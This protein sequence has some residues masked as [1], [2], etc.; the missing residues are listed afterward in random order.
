MYK[1]CS[2]EEVCACHYPHCMCNN[3]GGATSML[4]RNCS[5]RIW[6]PQS[7]HDEWKSYK[8]CLTDHYKKNLKQHFDTPLWRRVKRALKQS[9]T[10]M[11]LHDTKQATTK[12]KQKRKAPT[13]KR[14]QIVKRPAE[15]IIEK[16][17]ESKGGHLRTLLL[18]QALFNECNC[19]PYDLLPNVPLT[20]YPKSPCNDHFQNNLCDEDGSTT[21]NFL[22]YITSDEQSCLN[23]KKI[24]NKD[25]LAGLNKLYANVGGGM[26]T[27]FGF[28]NYNYEPA[29][30]EHEFQGFFRN[31][32][33]STSQPTLESIASNIRQSQLS[34]P[35]IW[36]SFMD[37]TSR[38]PPAGDAS[39]KSFKYPTKMEEE[40][41]LKTTHSQILQYL[42]R[43]KSSKEFS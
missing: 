7:S 26:D 19:D 37:L 22:S 32:T 17:Y 25:F 33:T 41:H 14:R 21:A 40:R 8:R 39:R 5:S 16:P 1:Y 36:K 3:C 2:G 30:R 10:M 18:Q 27:A 43:R 38:A 24:L 9:A 34:Q 6:S 28:R 11:N 35:H 42:G 23:V 4:Q 12:P 31:S 20:F 29:D 13:K 15:I